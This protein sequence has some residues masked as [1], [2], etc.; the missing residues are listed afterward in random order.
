M[1]SYRYGYSKLRMLSFHFD[2]LD[3][4]ISRDKYEMCLMDT[5]SE[6]LALAGDSI[7]DLVEPELRAAYEQDRNN[8]LPRPGNAY[9]KRKPGLFKVFLVHM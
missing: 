9:D 7:D 6:Y 8:Y 1:F 4:F 3:H 2:F 5:D